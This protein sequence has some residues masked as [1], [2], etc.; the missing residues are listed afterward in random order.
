M[1]G[2]IML[3]MVNHLNIKKGNALESPGNEGDA[4]RHKHQP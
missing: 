3:Q 2:M 4:N 1:I